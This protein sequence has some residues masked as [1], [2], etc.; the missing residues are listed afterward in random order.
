MVYPAALA[1]I[2]KHLLAQTIRAQFEK[3]KE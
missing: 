3:I 2:S 1:V